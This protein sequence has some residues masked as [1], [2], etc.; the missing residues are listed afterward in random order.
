VAFYA[1][2]IKKRYCRLTKA[3]LH[4]IYPFFNPHKYP[5]QKP[6]P[7]TNLSSHQQPPP[8]FTDSSI[9][10]ND[11]PVTTPS[12]R[13]F[14]SHFLQP[15]ILFFF[16]PTPHTPNPVGCAREAWAERIEKRFLKYDAANSKTMIRPQDE[17][18][19]QS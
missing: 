17:E 9:H 18:E 7:I 3:S 14:P 12:K 2:R 16:P 11:H 19:R 8:S 4:H 1:S 13:H 6:N 15:T 10:P 5:L